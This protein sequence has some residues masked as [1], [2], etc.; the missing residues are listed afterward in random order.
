MFR[1]TS[2]RWYRNDVAKEREVVSSEESFKVVVEIKGTKPI[3]GGPFDQAEAE[4][5][6]EVIRKAQ[7]ARESGVMVP[8][9]WL[10][11]SGR[12]VLAAYT[13]KVETPD[14]LVA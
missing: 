11:V 13:R 12:D 2:S 14:V 10:S 1:A 8:L 6:V 5:Q 4:R 3:V 7:E 9:T